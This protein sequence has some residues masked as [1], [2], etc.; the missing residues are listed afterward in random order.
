MIEFIIK[1][2]LIIGTLFFFGFFCFIIFQVFFSKKL[3]K[4]IDKY[5]KIP[6]NDKIN[7]KKK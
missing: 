3:K 2:S 1:N 7:S 5:S 6:L 4:N